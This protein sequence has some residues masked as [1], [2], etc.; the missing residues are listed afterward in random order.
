MSHEHH[1]MAEVETD[2]Q[3]LQRDRRQLWWVTV[4]MTLPILASAVAAEEMGRRPE[5]RYESVVQLTGTR[6]VQKAETGEAELADYDLE[7]DPCPGDQ[8][9]T[10]RGNGAFA[11]CMARYVPGDYLPAKVVHYWDSRGFWRYDLT[12]VG[13]CVHPVEPDAPGAFELSQECTDVQSFGVTTGFSCRRRPEHG[14][15]TTCP[16]MAK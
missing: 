14:L 9:Q 6:V 10:I 15:I 1:E 16:W 5:H 11:T 4:L 7:W 12:E 3:Q 13:G 2:P 8:M